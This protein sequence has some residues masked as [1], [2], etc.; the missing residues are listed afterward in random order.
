MCW[1]VIAPHLR[2]D[3]TPLA[4]HY[5]MGEDALCSM[6]EQQPSHM[7]ITVAH[8]QRECYFFPD[9]AS[10]SSITYDALA[11]LSNNQA[12]SRKRQ[13]EQKR[14]AA[15][16]AAADDTLDAPEATTDTDSSDDDDDDDD[17]IEE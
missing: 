7:A 13:S 6:R 4:S 8:P 17:T 1:A 15:R 11:G 16:R 2:I 12:V 5:D 3:A 10:P 9:H 14:A